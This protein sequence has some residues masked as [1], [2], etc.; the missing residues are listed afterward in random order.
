MRF[1]FALKVNLLVINQL[2]IIEGGL[3]VYGSS[4][5]ISSRVAFCVSY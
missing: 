5:F 1:F 2:S 4:L 3:N